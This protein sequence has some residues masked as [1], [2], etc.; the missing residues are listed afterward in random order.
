MVDYKQQQQ[1]QP[2]EIIT[3]FQIHCC[4]GM[5]FSG[6]AVVRNPDRCYW[7]YGFYGERIQGR[8]SRT[9]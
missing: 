8:D 4:E 1:Q 7:Q 2:C 5:F 6:E 3:L 9:I